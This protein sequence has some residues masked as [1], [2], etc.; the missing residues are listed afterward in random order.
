MSTLRLQAGSEN[1]RPPMHIRDHF[2]SGHRLKL[3]LHGSQI[4]PHN[5]DPATSSTSRTSNR[6][7]VPWMKIPNHYERIWYISRLVGN[8]VKNMATRKRNP[9]DA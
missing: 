8:S 9:R 2:K 4:M 1:S 5:D 7:G 3:D 6:P